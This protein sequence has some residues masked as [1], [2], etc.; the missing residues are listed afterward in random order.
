MRRLL[1]TAYGQPP[2]YQL[3]DVSVP[4][5]GPGEVRIRVQAVGLNPIDAKV[6]RGEMA[7]MM[8]LELPAPFASDVAGTVEAIGPGVDSL[9]VGDAVFGSVQSA[10]SELVVTDHET[11]THRP[12]DVPLATAAVA[13]MVGLTAATLMDEV[14]PGQT[15]VVIGASGGIGRFLVPWL[16]GRGFRVLATGE[17]GEA[18]RLNAAGADDVVDYREKDVAAAVAAAFPGG[19]DLVVDMI[20]QLDGLQRTVPLV[21]PGGQL[22]ST[23]FGPSAADLGA[24]IT[25]TYIRNQ[26]TPQRLATVAD[27]LASGAVS[28]AAEHWV[29]IG[30]AEG[31]LQ[32]YA[33]GE[34]RGKVA[35]QVDPA[36]EEG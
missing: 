10:S 25:V 11:V 16:A 8:P 35:I 5:P 27:A 19:A 30:D 20:N 24:D 2:S 31:V 1:L 4:E 23:L 13:P 21:R 14:L 33:T 3:A 29:P 18:A 32:Q 15:A 6:A 7:Q 36:V 34:L 28:I 9:A 12:S 17:P 26:S 22:V